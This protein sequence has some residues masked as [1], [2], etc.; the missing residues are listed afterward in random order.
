[1]KTT[2]GVLNKARKAWKTCC[3]FGLALLIA[4]CTVSLTSC[5]SKPSGS[6][7]RANSSGSY[8]RYANRDGN[9]SIAGYQIGVGFIKLM[10][11]DGSE[12][13]YTAEQT[14]QANVQS[15]QMLARSGAGLDDFIS[16]DGWQ[17]YK[18]LGGDSGIA[19]YQIGPDYIRVMFN[20][21]SVYLYTSASAGEEHI[22]NM[23]S[24]A[25]AGEKLNAYINRN[26]KSGYARKEQ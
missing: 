10:R 25:E 3:V 7:S 13:V 19:G 26:V 17:Q 12:S 18:N 21:S 15:M 9:S 20:D 23:K 14:G 16:S 22:D 11:N 2:S 5:D 1:M 4:L 24:L 8:I 6:N